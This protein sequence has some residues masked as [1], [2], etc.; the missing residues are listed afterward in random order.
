MKEAT[1]LVESNSYFFFSP[2]YLRYEYVYRRESGRCRFL[3]FFLWTKAHIGYHD[4]EL[5]GHPGKKEQ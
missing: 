2:G 4:N 5:K 3:P 1:V